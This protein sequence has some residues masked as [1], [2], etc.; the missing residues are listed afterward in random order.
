[1]IIDIYMIVSPKQVGIFFF[2]SVSC[3]V[4][5]FVISSFVSG[6]WE[7]KLYLLLALMSMGRKLQLLIWPRVP[8]SWSL[9]SHL[10]SLWDVVER[11]N[12]ILDFEWNSVMLYFI[13]IDKHSYWSFFFSFGDIVLL[14]LLIA[15]R[16]FLW[17]IY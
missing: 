7:R 11:C 16:Y 1:M 6:Y 4:Y 5:V 15:V 12:I 2:F 3:D 13:W 17:Q 9:Q 14:L 10:T 8:P